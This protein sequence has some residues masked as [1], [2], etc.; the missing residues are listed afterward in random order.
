M[1]D[2]WIIS[3][4]KPGH[5]NQSL[6]LAEA[7]VEIRNDLTFSLLTLSE[8]RARL[9]SNQGPRL[10]LSAGRATH[11]IS[12]LLSTRFRV[13][14]VLMMRPSL[15]SSCF[16]LI[17]VPEHD[18]PSV[19][20][21][22]HATCGAINRMK[23]AEKVPDSQWVLIGGPS[24]HV[25]W[26]DNIVLDAIRHL[27]ANG[28]SAVK[29]ATSRRTPESFL[30]LL[31]ELDNV[32][33][34]LPDQ[35][36]SHWLPQQLAITEKVIVSSDSVSMVYEALTAGCAVSLIRLE[37]KPDSRTQRGVTQLLKQGLVVEQGQPDI[38]PEKPFREATRF[39][40]IILNKGWL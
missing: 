16:N 10:I 20:Q 21:R 29:V 27:R 6:G 28:D 35:V 5:Q 12:W 25:E 3:D 14:N 24:K 23:P 15:P 8:A 4:A 39:A 31:K 37:S 9:F 30:R 11:L 18:A 34:Y 33:L 2:I 17:L 38:A 1:S 40:E 32:E 36:P 7:L 26:S 22:T 13:P 19:N